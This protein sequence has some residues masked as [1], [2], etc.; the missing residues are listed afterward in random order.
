MPGHEKVVSGDHC[1]EQVLVT[2]RI[3]VEYI[4]NLI[5]MIL[6]CENDFKISEF[7]PSRASKK[8]ENEEMFLKVSQFTQRNWKNWRGLLPFELPERKLG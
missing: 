1:S 4:L 6:K 7:Y 5:E 8:F 3:V 2:P